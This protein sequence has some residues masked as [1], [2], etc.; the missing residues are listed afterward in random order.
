MLNHLVIFAQA[1]ANTA[2]AAASATAEVASNVAAPAAVQKNVYGVGPMIQSWIRE[3]N[4]IPMAVAIIL[5]LMLFFTLYILLTKWLEQNKVIAQGRAIGA[6]FWGAP[7]LKDGAGKLGKDSA[8][9]QIVDD[10]LVAQDQHGKLTDAVDQHD[11][12]Q[13]ALLRSQAAVNSQLA[14]G[15]AFLATVGSTAPFIGLFG[16]VIGILSALV[17]IGAAGQASIDAVAGPVGEA[18]YMTAFGLLVAV[19]AVLAYNYLQRRNKAIS[20]SLQAFSTNIYG[21]MGSGGALRPTFRG[22]KPAGK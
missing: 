3:S 5:S 16:T 4:Y 12:V 9:R 22:S 21:Y 15:L 13:G 2:A 1:A 7:S 10:G 6:A 19:P 17:K 20:E 8:Y 11:W 18:L 14:G